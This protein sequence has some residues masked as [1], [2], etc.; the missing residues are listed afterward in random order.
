MNYLREEK[1]SLKSA[2]ENLNVQYQQRL[3]AMLPWSAIDPSVVVRP[4]YYPFPV[5]VLVPI[6]IGSIPMHP[7]MQPHPPNEQ[8]PGNIFG[9]DQSILNSRNLDQMI[10]RMNVVGY[11]LAIGVLRA[12]NQQVR[13]KF[14]LLR[15]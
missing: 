15:N 2:I 14:L 6:P 9:S 13:L 4:P 1:A 12:Q 5:L 10:R 8:L 7:S 3:R 11:V